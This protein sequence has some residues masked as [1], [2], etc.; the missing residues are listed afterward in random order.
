MDPITIAVLAVAFV[1]VIASRMALHDVIC[2]MD[3]AGA[4]GVDITAAD[5]IGGGDTPIVI[6]EQKPQHLC[7]DSAAYDAWG[8]TSVFGLDTPRWS[9]R[10]PTWPTTLQLGDRI[11]FISGT[12]TVLS[13]GFGHGKKEF[14]V[15]QDM[16]MAHVQRYIG[17]N[18]TWINSGASQIDT[19][20]TTDAVLVFHNSY[21]TKYPYR[22]GPLIHITKQL[23][24][25]VM[26]TADAW[27]EVFREVLTD[28]TPAIDP[29]KYYRLHAICGVA[30]ATTLTDWLMGIRFS[31]V[32]ADQWKAVAIGGGLTTVD[33]APKT[34]F[35]EDSIPP[36]KGNKTV[37]CE[38]LA[39]AAMTDDAT[40]DLWLEEYG[41]TTF[42][43][44]GGAQEV[45]PQPGGGGS[46]LISMITG[47]LNPTQMTNQ[48]G[49]GGF[50]F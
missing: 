11:D 46:D 8:S 42:E 31:T 14:V 32:G 38:V 45:A 50:T 33:P 47:F 29:D 40:I 5:F 41:G 3:N 34:I 30:E 26:T 12:T 7:I 27:D 43:A 49:G 2:H 18:T 10:P 21:G 20:L 1:M 15:A 37:V 6:D 16:N 17:E 25:A 9:L 36:F 24:A 28:D 39:S 23:A 48:G 13:E 4:A 22:G 44:G 19:P 35:L